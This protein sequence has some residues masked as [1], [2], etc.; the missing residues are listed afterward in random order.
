MRSRLVWLLVVALLMIPTI[1]AAQNLTDG[2]DLQFGRTITSTE[3]MT[4][5]GGRSIKELP[6][7]AEFALSRESRVLD[8][9]TWWQVSIIAGAEGAGWLPSSVIEMAIEGSTIEIRLYPDETCMSSPEEAKWLRG[10]DI[11][12]RYQHALLFPAEVELMEIRPAT[13]IFN[14]EIADFEAGI[15]EDLNAVLLPATWVARQSVRFRGPNWDEEH[16]WQLHWVCDPV[17][18]E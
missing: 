5:P 15:D 2:S 9:E 10:F 7:W 18:Q 14:G 13:L 12:R 11:L 16:L 4:N 3:L 17:P 6:E 8:G 1:V